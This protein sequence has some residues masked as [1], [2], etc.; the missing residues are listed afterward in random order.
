MS[1]VDVEKVLDRHKKF[2]AKA[3]VDRPLIGFKE[4]Q[5]EREMLLP[6]GPLYPESIDPQAL[7]RRYQ[8]IYA[9]RG[10]WEGDLPNAATAQRQ[11]SWA[12][13]MAGCQLKVQG[14]TVW[15]DPPKGGVDALEQG[16]TFHH[17][18]VDTLQNCIRVLASK[19]GPENPVGLPNLRGPGDIVTSLIGAERACM[20][21]YEAP[22][23]LK[24]LYMETNAVV[25]R[26]YAAIKEVLP[27]FHGGYIHEQLQMWAPEM[28]YWL[29]ND[30][31]TLL[32][33]KQVE[34]FFIPLDRILLTG[35]KYTCMHL[36]SSYLHILD[37]YLDTPEIAAIMI[38][39][40]PQP[41]LEDLIPSFLKIQKKKP[42][43]IRAPWTKPALERV[44]D[45]L[46][47]E[48]LCINARPGRTSPEAIQLLK[49]VQ[50]K[51]S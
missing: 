19:L 11:I 13:G 45:A 46:A 33:P 6:Q 35:K 51:E 22:D 25:M 5:P 28:I 9:A 29:S 43:L 4:M 37:V 47:P 17:E 24:A 23:K 1:R 27:Q 16:I 30:H 10:I 26:A 38:I 32:S 8:Q 44:L 15:A 48:G 2:W 39:C 14:D 40:D 7:A 49:Q 42:L 12:E 50:Q 31:A 3:K 20:S 21:I 36:H 34:E 18:W 41:P